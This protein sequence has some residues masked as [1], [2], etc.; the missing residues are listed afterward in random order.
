MPHNLLV[1]TKDS[2]TLI[3]KDGNFA[4]G[5]FSPKTLL[6]ATLDFGGSLILQSYEWNT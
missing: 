4:F 2:E 1:M 6:I 3:S 5:F